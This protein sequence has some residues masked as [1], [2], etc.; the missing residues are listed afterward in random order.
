MVS[1]NGLNIRL[2]FLLVLMQTLTLDFRKVLKKKSS[3]K[4]VQYVSPSVWAWRQG[5]VH[6]KT[7]HRFSTLFISF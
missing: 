3:N 5:R 2:I 1:I 4:T 7:E 6:G